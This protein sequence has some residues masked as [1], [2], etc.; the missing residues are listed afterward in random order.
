MEIKTGKTAYE[1]LV[2]STNREK[3][4]CPVLPAGA[5]QLVKYLNDDGIK[6]EF[7]DLC[8]C[9]DYQNIFQKQIEMKGLKAVVFSIRNIDNETYSNTKFYLPMMKTM[10]MQCR[11]RNLYTLI[12]GSAV[13]INSQGIADYLQPDDVCVSYDLQQVRQLLCSKIKKEFRKGKAADAC[14]EYP[15]GFDWEYIISHADKN[16]FMGRKTGPPIVGL[17]TKK[18]CRFH[19]IHCSITKLEGHV[20]RCRPCADVLNDLKIMEESGVQDCFICDNIFQEP[21]EYAIELC[22]GIVAQ[23]IHMK[24]T[25]YLAPCNV[26]AELIRWMKKAGCTNVQF[27]VDTA[28]E[29][30]LRLWGK[31]FTA[32]DII[33]AGKVCKEEGMPC[34]HSLII[35][36]IGETTETLKETL[37][38]LESAEASFIWAT[39][40]VRVQK[41]TQLYQMLINEK[42][43][44]ADPNNPD[45]IRPVFYIAPE[46][47][48]IYQEI[49]WEFQR[50]NPHILFKMNGIQ[51]KEQGA[52]NENHRFEYANGS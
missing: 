28:C 37:F 21:Y 39:L 34:S 52:G 49:I 9:S 17:Q 32:S 24:W 50:K 5:M 31:G 42:K 22:K 4:P 40:G 26:D 13:M 27:G 29:K 12:G 48:D 19:C 25:C 43:I 47:K 15:T 6:T 41:E 33:H 38:C 10:M 2:V 20:I 46:I 51:E 30:L 8:F 23:E 14:N 11:N 44:H 3:S 1:V 7:L 18:G 36:G 35:G 45:L 16:Y